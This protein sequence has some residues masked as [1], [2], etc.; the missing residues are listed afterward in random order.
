LRRSEDN[1]IEAHVVSVSVFIVNY[2]FAVQLSA[3]VYSS[4]LFFPAL[5]GLIFGV[6]I[7]WLILLYLNWLVARLC[8]RCGLFT[9]LS[10]NRVQSVIFG[11]ITSIFAAELMASGRWFRWIG[12]VWIAAVALNLSAA[13]L[14]ALKN[15]DAS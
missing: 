9:D 7:F 10:A 8:W 15:D 5:V 6:W 1:G 11:I 13:L 14:L 4:W 12:V 2:L 3:P